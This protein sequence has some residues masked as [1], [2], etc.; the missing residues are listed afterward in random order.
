MLHFVSAPFASFFLFAVSDATNYSFL[1]T[2]RG[3]S[4][5]KEKP[6]TGSF[7]EPRKD[8]G[9]QIVCRCYRNYRMANLS[10]PMFWSGM[11]D[12]DPV[13][14]PLRLNIKGKVEVGLMT[15]WK[16]MYKEP[17]TLQLGVFQ[18][19]PS[20]NL[21]S[22]TLLVTP[23]LCYREKLFRS[24]SCH[25]PLLEVTEL[26]FLHFL[27]CPIPRIPRFVGLWPGGS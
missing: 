13:L 9:S 14:S 15:V 7:P 24:T 12:L 22:P 23:P 3:L 4:D 2:P 26:C 8:V 20:S 19:Y 5:P 16:N 21:I 11:P 10:F 25:F 17:P 1:C 18:L 27:L 6:A